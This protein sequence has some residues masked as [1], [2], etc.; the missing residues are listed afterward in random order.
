[1]FALIILEYKCICDCRK[2][3]PGLLL[4]AAKDFNIDLSESYI[5]GDS[6]RDIEAGENAGVKKCIQVEVNKANGL[7]DA[8]KNIVD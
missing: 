8:V 3:K 4:Q 6:Y 2:P 5:I 1:M 7:L